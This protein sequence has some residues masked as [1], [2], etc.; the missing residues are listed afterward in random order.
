MPQR[1]RQRSA[2]QW[3]SKWGPPRRGSCKQLGTCKQ[4]TFS[5]LG[6]SG[7]GACWTK[8]SRGFRRA[9]EFANHWERAPQ[10]HASLPSHTVGTPRG[11]L[12]SRQGSNWPV[13]TSI[14]A[15]SPELRLG[16]QCR[17]ARPEAALLNPALAAAAPGGTQERRWEGCSPRRA[18][19]PGSWAGL[20]A[21]RPH[22]PLPPWAHQASAD[23]GD[24]ASEQ[25][26]GVIKC[27]KRRSLPSLLPMAYL[28]Q[29]QMAGEAACR[30]C[31]ALV[32]A[33]G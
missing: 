1:R 26:A 2:Q 31:A 7:C 22:P 20:G 14:P 17:E 24:G 8:P 19:V 16:D 6:C 23:T 15:P 33:T 10:S 3:F 18:L 32:A 13:P 4:C 11:Q 12:P 9:L 27:Q 21:G 25:E 28:L 30:F 5:G 29:G